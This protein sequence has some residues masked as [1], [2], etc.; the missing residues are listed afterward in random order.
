MLDKKAFRLLFVGK[1]SCQ[2]K[3]LILLLKQ[4]VRGN[5][6]KA[7]IIIAIIKLISKIFA[8]VEAG[9]ICFRF[10]V[11]E[12]SLLNLSKEYIKWPLLKSS[13]PFRCFHY[14]YE[15]H[16]RG[17]INNIW[18]RGFAQDFGI[19]GEKKI[20]RNADDA[21]QIALFILNDSF[22]CS[23]FYIFFLPQPNISKNFCIQ[24]TPIQI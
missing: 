23:S 1:Y 20:Y 16:P 17:D 14:E 15:C 10:G 21:A 12:S 6:K 22:F 3:K 8:H 9:D 2:R 5:Y 11:G 13:A 19:D 7:F 18:C 4:F 24:P